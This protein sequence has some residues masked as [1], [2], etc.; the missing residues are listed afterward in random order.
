ME[1]ILTLKLKQGIQ[2]HQ[3]GNLKEAEILYK[4]VLHCNTFFAQHFGTDFRQ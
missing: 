2:E 3:K 1:S 4:N